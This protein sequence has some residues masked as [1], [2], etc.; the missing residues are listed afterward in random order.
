MHRELD[1]DA[2][3]ADLDEVLA[4]YMR[5]VDRGEQVDQEAL[6]AAHPDL[7]AELREY[8]SDAVAINQRAAA[9]TADFAAQATP[10][11]ALE[12]RCPSCHAPM[13]VAVDTGNRLRRSSSAKRFCS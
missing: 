5:R 10:R 13:D 7:A 4:D 11:S 6:I 9:V 3:G 12:V 1:S 2:D 8:F